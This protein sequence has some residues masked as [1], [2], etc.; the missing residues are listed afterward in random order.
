VLDF[1]VAKLVGEDRIGEDRIEEPGGTSQTA[2]TAAG[3]IVGTP[4]YMAP[5]QF[6]A[7]PAD[8][9]TDVYSLGV[10]AYEMLSG[11]LP[12]G[13]G[14]LADVVLAQA[15]GVP[16]MPPDVVSASA[17]RAIR[18][19]LDADPDRRPAS[20]QAFATMLSAALEI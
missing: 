11:E 9:R 10:V 3:M 16:P 17:E 7:I 19:A 15:R 2:L 6:K 4:A 20:P 5:E 12:F 18:S 14:T 1:G 13:R 8:A